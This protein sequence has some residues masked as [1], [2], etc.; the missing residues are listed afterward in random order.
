MMKLDYA[1]WRKDFDNAKTAA[2][3]THLLTVRAHINGKQHMTRAR[4]TWSTA[5][6]FGK[7]E[8]EAAKTLAANGGTTIVELDREDQA[9]LAGDDWRKYIK[10]E[11]VEPVP[12]LKRGLFA[13]IKSFI[14]GLFDVMTVD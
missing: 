10:I 3:K 2:D 9:E 7:M 13:S 12:Q 5:A 8:W 14:T 11:I 1:L 6:R 4:V